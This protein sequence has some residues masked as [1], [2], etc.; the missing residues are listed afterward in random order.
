MSHNKI[1]SVLM[2]SVVALTSFVLTAGQ[3]NYWKPSVVSGK[4]SNPDNWSLGHVPTEDEEVHFEE[5]CP[6]CAVEIDGDFT[7]LRF[8]VLSSSSAVLTLTGSGSLTVSGSNEYIRRETLVNGPSLSF[9][10]TLMM[11]APVEVRSGSITCKT[12]WIYKASAGLEI[13]GGTVECTESVQ[14]R[15]NVAGREF[16]TVS[17]GSFATPR[18]VSDSENLHG[19]C[20]FDLSISGGVVEIGMLMV[21]IPGTF[22]QTGGELCLSNGTI[23]FEKVSVSHTGGTLKFA[24]NMNYGSGCLYETLCAKLN[25]TLDT[26]SAY[27]CPPAGEF[28]VV[29]N[30]LAVR[31]LGSTDVSPAYIDID[32]LTLT[33]GFPFS[34]SGDASR[35]F[36]VYGPMTVRTL[37]DMTYI[38]DDRNDVTVNVRGRVT[39]E[40][41]DAADASVSRTVCLSGL[42]SPDGSGELVVRGSGTLFLRPV[43]GWN[44]FKEV[45]AENGATLELIDCEDDPEDRKWG[46][47]FTEKLVLG[48]SATLRLNAN[49]SFVRLTDCE[50]DPTARIV[51]VVPETFSGSASWPI[52]QTTGE[53]EL[54]AALTGQ[55]NLVGAPEGTAVKCENGQLT[56]YLRGDDLGKWSGDGVYEWTGAG[57]NNE[58]KT[59][60]NWQGGAAPAEK[61]TIAFGASPVT[62]S[63]YNGFTPSGSTTGNLKFM[64]NAIESF[65]IWGTTQMTFDDSYHAIQSYANILQTVGIPMRTTQAQIVISACSAAPLE[66]GSGGFVFKKADGILSLAGDVRL[67]CVGKSVPQIG[68]STTSNPRTLPRVTVLSDASL[69]V[70]AQ[71]TT[72]SGDDAGFRINEGGTLTFAGGADLNYCR[73]AKSHLQIINGTMAINV[74]FVGGANQAFGGS[75]RLDITGGTRSGATSSRV[76]FANSLNVNLAA[77]ATVTADADNAVAISIAGSPTVHVSGGWTYGPADGVAT[78][79]T[80]SERALIV[81]GGATLTIEADGG[82]IRFADPFV[83]DFATSRLPSILAIT[84]GTLE[85][86]GTFETD[87]GVKALRG[88]NVSV[89]ADQT[90]GGFSVEPGSS[91]IFAASAALDVTGDV[92]LVGFAPTFTHAEEAY[93]WRTVLRVAKKASIS[94]PPEG[95]EIAFRTVE[96]EGTVEIQCRRICGTTV[97]LR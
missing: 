39:V 15:R 30:A 23:D 77:W 33:G 71:T 25:E 5:D 34:F 11:Y 75:G 87:V 47:L 2:G 16:L 96:T 89:L 43:N 49:G 74:P 94:L 22:S 9:A 97:I 27:L 17:A 26:T 65:N 69:T 52:L 36:N 79:T 7:A 14:Y 10:G 21:Q 19:R 83:G 48:P 88:G 60:A 64:E 3:V 86:D 44:P 8:W 80:S 45:S 46:A 67:S 56:V 61:N 6:S 29:T 62:S 1:K 92:D 55:V 4:W 63:K 28:L 37:A 32:T 20:S 72:L 51:V 50:I 58:W 38:E 66:V 84:N 24:G 40:T 91:V 78:G 54:P 81:Q 73:S 57:A 12:C 13:T 41:Q 76:L 31:G 85:L 68:F 42:A 18:M 70:S 35:E 53:M 90:I 82:T 93:G 59:G 95:G